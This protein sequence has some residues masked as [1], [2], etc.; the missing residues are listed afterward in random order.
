MRSQIVAGTVAL[1]L[2]G[3]AA[4]AQQQPSGTPDAGASPH[5]QVPG[6]NATPPQAEQN[7]KQGDTSVQPAPGAMPGSD[8]VPSRLSE[9][10]AADDKLPTV[11]YTFKDLS[12]D[13]RRAIYQAVSAKPPANAATAAGGPTNVELGSVLP[14]AIPLAA[15]P[16]DVVN[17]VPR[18]KGFQYVKAGDKLLLVAP[19]NRIV[20]GVFT[21]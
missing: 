20:V 3:S 21:P 2:L 9:K 19:A 15:I 4:W 5:G 16:D 10:N 1:T 6:P 14:E 17:Q 7:A 11:A 8:A 13:Q 18:I 12:A